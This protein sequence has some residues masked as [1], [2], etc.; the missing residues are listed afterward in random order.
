VGVNGAPADQ[1]RLRRDEFEVRF[2]AK[3]TRFTERELAF[4]DFDGC[5]IGLKVCGNRRGIIG[6][7]WR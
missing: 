5:G 7:G 1:T 6:D 2:I 4:I 3:P